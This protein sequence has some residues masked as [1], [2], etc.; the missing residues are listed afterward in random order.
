MVS[1]PRWMG[2]PLAGLIGVKLAAVL[3]TVMG[4]Q[5]RKRTAMRLD[6]RKPPLLQIRIGDMAALVDQKGTKPSMRSR[7]SPVRMGRAILGQ[8]L[9]GIGIGHL[10]R[11]FQPGGDGRH[12]AGQFQRAIEVEFPRQCTIRSWSQ[13]IASQA[14]ITL[15]DA[16]QLLGGELAADLTGQ[17]KFSNI[18][19]FA[20]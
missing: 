4:I 20:V 15:G 8:P 18:R 3:C 14:L 19:P 7:F 17:I 12:R 10:E 9:P 13:P 1:T 2:S 5:T 6:S 11:I 16:Y